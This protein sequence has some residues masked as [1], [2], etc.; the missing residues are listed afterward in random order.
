MEFKA[1]LI[2][3]DGTLAD[4]MPYWLGLPQ[5]SLRR[6]GIPEP[7]GFQDAIRSVPVWEVAEWLPREF[8]ALTAGGSLAEQWFAAMGEHYRRHITLKAGAMELL[9]E[10]RAAGLTLVI[11]SATRRDLLETAMGAMDVAGRVDL[12]FSEKDIGS[13]RTEVP[14]R[15]I[16][17]RL[18]LALEEMF[19]IE[20]A[21]R[22]LA[23]AAALG[24]GTVGVYDESMAGSQ[25][26]V[27][28]VADVYLP[29]LRERHAMQRLLQG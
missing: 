7:E 4:S 26:E 25:D 19:L 17:E 8:P 21:P 3:F 16:A 27:R 12:V 22:N 14:Y 13:K 18:G 28:A 1:A 2:D 20:D 24:L 9:E 23:A 6:A 10:L 11:L 5:E 15:F 29:D